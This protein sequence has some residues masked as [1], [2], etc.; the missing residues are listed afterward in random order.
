MGDMC[1]A[2]TWREAYAQLL[3][4]QPL[5]D[6]GDLLPPVLGPPQA[7]LALYPGQVRLGYRDEQG[8]AH[9]RWLSP[10]TLRLAVCQESLSLGWLPAGAV[11][12]G[13]GPHGPW[14][15]RFL[16]PGRHTLTLDIPD[17]PPERIT[18]PLPSLFFGGCGRDCVLWAARGTTWHPH[19]PLYHAPLPNVSSDGGRIC[20]GANTPPVL[21]AATLEEAWRLFL[22]APFNGD[23]ARGKS[24]AWPGDVRERLWELARRSRTPAWY[25]SRDLLPLRITLEEAVRHGFGAS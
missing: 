3:P 17:Q 20:W 15:L 5:E 16:P 10:A 24:R 4:D 22:A 13:I 8:I 6:L 19:L 18:V 21:S 11:T 2:L 14:L 23:H 7:L 12:G 1:A 25:P 9:T